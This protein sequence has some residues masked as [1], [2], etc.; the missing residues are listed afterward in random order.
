M[1]TNK[2]DNSSHKEM[3][4]SQEKYNK[5]MLYKE[6]KLY[7]RNDKHSMCNVMHN[8]N[9]KKCK[10]QSHTINTNWSLYHIAH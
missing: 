5:S 10:F 8:D 4:L 2:V 7:Q 6:T 9:H 3:Y 1:H